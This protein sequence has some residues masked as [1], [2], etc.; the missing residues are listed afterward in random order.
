MES[1]LDLMCEPIPR[2]FMFLFPVVDSLVVTQMGLTPVPFDEAY[3][4]LSESDLK[5]M[6]EQGWI[7]ACFQQSSYDGVQ[8]F[9]Y[10]KPRKTGE[11]AE[12]VPEVPCHRFKGRPKHP[13]DVLALT[14]FNAIWAD[15]VPKLCVSFERNVR[16]QKDEWV[17]F[18]NIAP[19]HWNP[20]IGAITDNSS[21]VFGY[22]LDPASAG[23][24]RQWFINFASLP[25]MSD[26]VEVG[27]ISVEERIIVSYFPLMYTYS[28]NEG[29][30]TKL[31]AEAVLQI[32]KNPEMFKRVTTKEN[33]LAFC[34][35]RLEKE[36]K[37][38]SKDRDRLLGQIRQYQAQ[39]NAAFSDLAMCERLMST[40][41]GI[42]AEFDKR[43]EM[44]WESINNIKTLEG[45]ALVGNCMHAFTKPLTVTAKIGKAKPKE[46]YLG[47][48]EIVMSFKDCQTRIYNRDFTVDAM[49]G[50]MQAPHVFETGA[51]CLGS[52]GATLPGLISRLDVCGCINLILAYLQSVNT[53]DPAGRYVERWPTAEE[54]EKAEGVVS[55]GIN[56]Y[57]QET[58]RHAG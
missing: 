6:V 9:M 3:V 18:V 32:L 12:A 21:P 24:R 5:S 28:K 56:D 39:M 31:F 37:E 52:I 4:L 26:N 29:A 40:A 53:D 16:P 33:Y 36:R 41:T 38:A 35:G 25:I 43:M 30:V 55:V 23:N 57:V 20:Q 14:L 51:P 8:A 15:V 11:K 2:G 47:R 13:K 50:R 49:H 42:A 44:E 22:A 1:N 54:V 7:V 10:K 46:Y 58:Y 34:K 17:L 19:G 45:F 27:C 48:F